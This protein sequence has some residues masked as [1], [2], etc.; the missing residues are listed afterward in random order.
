MSEVDYSARDLQT[1]VMRLQE[2]ELQ[3]KREIE[4]LSIKNFYM[5]NQINDYNKAI[6]AIY[7][8]IENPGIV[9]TYHYHILR[10]HRSE[11]PGLWE[12]IDNLFRLRK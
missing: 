7:A 11:W 10:K 5:Q 12:K 6:N 1:S 8:V 9:P 2:L 3:L 4:R